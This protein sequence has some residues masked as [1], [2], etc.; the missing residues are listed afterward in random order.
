MGI[1]AHTLLAPG[2]QARDLAVSRSHPELV[3][4]PEL[5][6]AAECDALARVAAL[7]A[8]V[9]TAS[10][11]L[12]R[13]TS[14]L[15]RSAL[16][17]A[18]GGSASSWHRTGRAA[19][20]AWSR[21]TSIQALLACWDAGIVADDLIAYHPSRGGHMHVQTDGTSTPRGRYRVR[22]ADGRYVQMHTRDDIVA[23]ASTWMAA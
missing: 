2:I 14:G 18:V 1:P 22:M 12:P 11:E 3:T 8:Q 6:T 10:G 15:R 5:W 9:G 17:R 16:N 7:I 13:I 23:A 19:D 20:I 21:Q 4:P